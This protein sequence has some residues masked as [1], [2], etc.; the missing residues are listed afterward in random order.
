M[1]PKPNIYWVF[2][3]EE[4]IKDLSKSELLKIFVKKIGFIKCR[5]VVADSYLVELEA[6]F[7]YGSDTGTARIE[8]PTQYIKA[9]VS[10]IEGE[11]AIGFKIDK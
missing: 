5:K 10:E 8:I 4:G 7:T 1:K 9:V 11:K 2:L 6:E 3:T